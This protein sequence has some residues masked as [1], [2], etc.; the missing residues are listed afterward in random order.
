MAYTTLNKMVTV[1]SIIAKIDEL[2]H[3]LVQ[4][5]DS[6]DYGQCRRV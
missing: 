6:A 3:W 4:L 1:L 2:K 5:L